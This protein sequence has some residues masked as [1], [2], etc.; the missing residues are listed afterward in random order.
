MPKAVEILSRRST[1]EASSASFPARPSTSLAK[2]K[3]VIVLPPTADCSLE[4]SVSVIIFFTKKL[5]KDGESKHPC[6]TLTEAK[7]K[8][9]GDEAATEVLDQF[10]K[11][12]CRV[13]ALL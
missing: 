13:V 10:M 5:K 1:R 3:L 8:S 6:L 12:D 2:L 4:I 9:P 7:G 11:V